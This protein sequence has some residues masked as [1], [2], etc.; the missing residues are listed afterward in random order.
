MGGHERA[1]GAG[2]RAGERPDLA[3]TVESPD[4]VRGPAGGGEADDDVRLVHADRVE[5]RGAGGGVVLGPLEGAHQRLRAA[6]DETH[7]EVGAHPVGRR[8]LACVEHPQA[9]GGPG[10]H[11]DQTPPSLHPLVGGVDDRGDGRQD[12]AHGGRDLV[13]EVVDRLEGLH[14]PHLVDVGGARV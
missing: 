14:G 10:A 3:R 5:V 12:A 9:A 4:H 6:G 8:A 1:L 11:V 2:D 7:D 13:V